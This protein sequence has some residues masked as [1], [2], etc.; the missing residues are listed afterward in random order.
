MA[1]EYFPAYH[2][3]LETIEQLSDAERGR[4]FTA[5]LLYS[6]TGEAPKLSGN[7]RFVFPAIRSQ[8]DRDRRSYDEYTQKQSRNARQRWSA[9][10]AKGSAAAQAAQAAQDAQ[11]A[12][13]PH[14]ASHRMCGDARD[15]MEREKKTENAKTKATERETQRGALPPAPP[16]A[17]ARRF[18]PPSL[19]EVAA[20][21]RERASAVDAR[22]FVDFYA[23]KGWQVGQSPMRDWK[24]AVRTWEARDASPTAGR[25]SP[26]AGRTGDVLLRHDPKERRETYR[27]AVVD[28]DGE[29]GAGD[30]GGSR[31]E[32]GESD[33]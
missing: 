12:Q 20:Y 5:C 3:Y 22:R 15:A 7:E 11:D 26:A 14:A 21:C 6:K 13:D 23:S 28:F 24:A 25:A 19:E 1:R 32:W 31:G 17:A 8:I 4:L 33:K 27:A 29:P 2:S 18:A 9:C 30:A 16:A 10:G